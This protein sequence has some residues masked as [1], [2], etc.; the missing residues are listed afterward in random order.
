[1]FYLVYKI[2]NTLDGKYY[3]GAHKTMNKDD[4]YMGSGVYL[5]KAIKKYGIENFSKEILAECP[6]EFDMFNKER[7]LVVL[8]E[9]SYNLK[10]GGYGGFDHI[11]S[12]EE[13]RIAKNKRAMHTTMSRHHHLLKEWGRK[14]GKRCIELYGVNENWVKAGRTSFLGKHHTDENKRKIGDANAK[15]QSGEGNSQFGTMWITDEIISKKISKN[16]PIP[17]GWRKGRVMNK[18]A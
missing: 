9:N 3:I 5:R 14:G 1:M 7:E 10:E 16:D 2:T 12:N 11:N 17:D 15:H 4:G 18:A 8:C 13:L 6:S